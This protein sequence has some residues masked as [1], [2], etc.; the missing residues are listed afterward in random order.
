MLYNLDSDVLGEC[1]ADAILP[2]SLAGF[3]EMQFPER[4]IQSKFFNR[5]LMNLKMCL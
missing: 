2:A 4:K 1:F 3:I 5:L